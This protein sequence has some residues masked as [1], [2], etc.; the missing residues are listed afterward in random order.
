L[1]PCHGFP[2][3]AAQIA[4]MTRFFEAS[5]SIPFARKWRCTHKL[6]GLGQARLMSACPP[7][8]AQQRTYLEI[9]DANA[10]AAPV[11]DR[12]LSRHSGNANGPSPVQTW[13]TSTGLL[14]QEDA[15]EMRNAY[16]ENLFLNLQ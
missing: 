3:G 8:A 2:R 13:S 5:S 4:E 7:N 9:V 1:E 16:R 6:G 11:T 10:Q 15:T 14:V 12:A